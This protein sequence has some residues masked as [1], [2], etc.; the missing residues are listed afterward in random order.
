MV[1]GG[2]AAAAG[3]ATAETGIGIGVAAIGS[4]ITLEGVAAITAGAGITTAGINNFSS[5]KAKYSEAKRNSGM[6]SA[7]GNSVKGAD[8]IANAVKK[9]DLENLKW[10]DTVQKHLAERPYQDSKLLIQ[11]IMN[12]GSPIF[13]PQG[14]SGLFWKVEGTYNGS[15]GTYELLIDPDTN[16]VWHFLFR[17]GN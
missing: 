12:K 8:D 16:T 9:I 5:D 17:G 13:D 11:E 3:A 15:K 6:G 4:A 10:S 14:G 2:A 1:G 7:V